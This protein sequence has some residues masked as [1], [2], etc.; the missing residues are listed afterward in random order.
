MG[1]SWQQDEP[2]RKK[3][4]SPASQGA[5]EFLFNPYPEDEKYVKIGRCRFCEKKHP[6]N[7]EVNH[8]E[9]RRRSAK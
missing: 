9:K 7:K 6:F 1:E 3:H 8:P 5:G 2:I 4:F